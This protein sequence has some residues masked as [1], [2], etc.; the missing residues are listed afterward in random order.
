MK[1]I[2]IVLSIMALSLGFLLFKGFFGPSTPSAAVAKEPSAVVTPKGDNPVAQSMLDILQDP[3]TQWVT[4][5]SGLKYVDLVVG[6]GEQ[7]QIAQTVTVHYQGIL[8]TGKTFDSS[9][10]RNQPLEFRLGVGQVIKGWD[11]G[12]SSMKINGKRL[13][14]IPPQLAYGSRKVGP[15]LP[16]STLIFEVEL[17]GASS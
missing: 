3:N 9:Y 8:E 15:I 1:T 17:L 11:E 13:L 16:D 10:K 4:T 14:V 2:I 5:E 12:V 6:E 7:P